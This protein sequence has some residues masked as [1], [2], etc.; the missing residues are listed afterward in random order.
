MAAA[1]GE[2]WEELGGGIG[3]LVTK[4]HGFGADALLLAAF[5][6]PHGRER[7]CDLGTGCGILPFLWLRDGVPAHVDAVDIA[8][9]AAELGRRSCRKNGL[10][11]RLCFL[12]ADWAALPGSLPR[13]GY[14]RVTCNPPYFPPF[15]GGVNREDAARRA[16]H[17]PDGG[18]LERLCRSAAGLLK[19]GGRFCLCHR[20]ERVC[21][22]FIAL[23]GAGLEPKVFRP[24]QVRADAA[25]WLFLCE[26][27]KGGKPGL[28][29]LP[30][31]LT[32][33]TG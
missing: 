3:V 31:L 9:E 5:A 14:D 12:T 16:R 7:V 17:E 4:E 8:P 6:R 29:F 23:R 15:S 18:M 10:S 26:A 1:T 30:P 20:P 11:D 28:R 13:G 22:V 27:R 21:D 2:R 33:G 25:P 32:E 19:N 24:V